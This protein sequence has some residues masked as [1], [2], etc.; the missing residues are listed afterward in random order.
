M[1]LTKARGN[2]RSASQARKPGKGM[3]LGQRDSPPRHVA[4]AVGMAA[5]VLQC[6]GYGEWRRNHY[7]MRR[8]QS[9]RCAEGARLRQVTRRQAGELP[10][11]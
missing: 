3:W 8:Q 9:M 5:D 10:G 7:C 1:N 4:A 11:F 2:A 6:N